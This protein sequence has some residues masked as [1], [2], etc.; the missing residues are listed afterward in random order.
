MCC[1]IAFP[2]FSLSVG[3][4]LYFRK[5]GVHISILVFIAQCYASTIYAVALC[6]CPS[7]C[8]SVTSQ[9]YTKMAKHRVMQT[10]QHDGVYI[11][12]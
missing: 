1:V 8:L 9:S 5:S 6:V 12:F 10:T 4:R 11:A 3:F 2:V 7:S